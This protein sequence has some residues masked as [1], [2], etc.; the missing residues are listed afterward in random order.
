MSSFA[1]LLSLFLSFGSSTIMVQTGV[2]SERK[3]V[4]DKETE[5][6]KENPASIVIGDIST[7]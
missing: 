3:V 1:I 2:K 6:N 7:P 5:K 4:L